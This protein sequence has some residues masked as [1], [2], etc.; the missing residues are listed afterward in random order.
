M[1][2]PLQGLKSMHYSYNIHTCFPIIVSDD[3]QEPFKIDL[4]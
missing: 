4:F 3:Q 2:T 1:L